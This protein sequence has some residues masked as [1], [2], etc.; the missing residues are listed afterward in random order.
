MSIEGWMR[1]RLRVAPR[2]LGLVVLQRG[3][4]IALMAFFIGG[5]A[6]SS[7]GADYP[8]VDARY[9]AGPNS[10]QVADRPS[11]GLLIDSIMIHDTEESYA[12]TVA[13]F[14]KT[15]A[16]ASTQYLISGQTNSSD[17]AVTQF[18]A[19]K[20]WAKHVNN[21]WFNQHSIGIENIGFVVAPAG[22][23]TR[24]MYERLADLVGWAV[25]KYR[26]PLDR[27]HILGHDNIPNSGD[28]L[29]G[30]HVQHWDPGPSF[31]WPYLMDLVHAAYERWSHHAALP[32]AEI[33]D[34]YRKD[35]PRI[36]VISV[37]DRF[38]SGRDSI[39]WTT[40]HQ[41]AFTNV[42]ADAGHR[43]E[44]DTLVRGASDPST[45]APSPLS[46]DLTLPFGEES[47]SGGAPPTFNELDF[48]CDNFP[49]DLVT[50][51]T[52]VRL[53]AGDLRAKA[54]WGQ[55]FALLGTRRVDGVL[56]DKINFSGTDGWV[57]DSDTRA[58][59]GALVRFRGGNSPTTLFSGPEY[60]A[61]YGSFTDLDTRIC[62]DNQY[63][64]SRA[65]QTYVARIKRFSQ[66]REW[67]QIDYN[68]RVAWV[69]AG[70]VDVLAQ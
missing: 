15:D 10:Y 65:G 3:W 22:Y 32:P 11:D 25:W 23:F 69:P 42:Y 20:N 35:D 47:T 67:Y 1:R 60:P 46:G 37:G 29:G 44:L 62:P 49:M 45:Y 58:G 51:L 12:G 40:G 68:H 41:N 52:N 5:F 38:A 59:W 13:A 54:A 43:P 28:A 66:G 24:A 34:R 63:G 17:P 7:A 57:R 61:V 50:G 48:S 14:T 55:E 36:R 21:F 19:D 8:M 2:R 31:D 33:P 9:I 56:Y 39:L 30:P 26:I 4:K 18:V 70:E 16:R 27:A 6:A 53:S 64:Y